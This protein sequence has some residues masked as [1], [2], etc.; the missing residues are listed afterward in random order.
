MRGFKTI[1][2]VLIIT[3]E[4][5]NNLL[6]TLQAVL[7]L[8]LQSDS[9]RFLLQEKLNTFSTQLQDQLFCVVEVRSYS[10]MKSFRDPSTMTKQKKKHISPSTF[11]VKSILSSSIRAVRTSWS[12]RAPEIIRCFL[13]CTASILS[14]TVPC[15]PKIMIYPGYFICLVLRIRRI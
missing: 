6:L 9:P 10:E 11:Y 3:T 13:A 1:S 8:N 12:V 14:S 2:N 7:P 4:H 5:Q 15:P